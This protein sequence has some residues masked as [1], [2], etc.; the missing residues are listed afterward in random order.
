MNQLLSLCL[1]LRR[2]KLL[3]FTSTLQWIVFFIDH[4]L[5]CSW[6]YETLCTL[7]EFREFNHIS[8]WYVRFQN[9]ATSSGS[10]SRSFS[11]VSSTVPSQFVAIKIRS[12]VF[13]ILLNIHWL[14]VVLLVTFV[15]SVAVVRR[16]LSNSFGTALTVAGQPFGISERFASILSVFSFPML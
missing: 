5:L 4:I 2:L 10:T 7:H 8:A 3:T 16:F 14:S 12:G 6:G 11:V 9:N 13:F 1:E 15:G